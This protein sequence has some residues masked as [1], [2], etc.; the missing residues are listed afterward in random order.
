MDVFFLRHAEAEPGSGNDFVRELTEKGRRQAD[1]AA[2]YLAEKFPKTLL[3]VTSPVTRARQTAEVVATALDLDLRVAD[4]LACGMSPAECFEG[5]AEFSDCGGP[6]VLVGH[7]PD[8][9][10][11]IA[12]LTGAQAGEGFH[13]RKATLAGIEVRSIGPGGGRLQFLVPS[14]LMD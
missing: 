7:E 12:V 13:V 3:V 5:L 6:V 2:R 8:F 10:T 1:R 9:S 4:W 14:R 11:A